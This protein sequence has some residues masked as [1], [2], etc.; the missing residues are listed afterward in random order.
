MGSRCHDEE[1]GAGLVWWFDFRD[2]D[3]HREDLLS[4]STGRFYN[5][6]GNGRTVVVRCLE[7]AVS[8][9][10]LHLDVMLVGGWTVVVVIAVRLALMHVKQRRFGIEAEKRYAQE[11][12]DQPHQPDSI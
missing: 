2:H 12:C 6:Y 9:R 11:N 8:G 5:Y 1:W 4:V 10:Q 7:L 3:A